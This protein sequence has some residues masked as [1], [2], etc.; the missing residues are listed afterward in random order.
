MPGKCGMQRQEIFQLQT[1]LNGICQAPYTN[2][3][4]KVVLCLC[5]VADHSTGK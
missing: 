5:P 3:Q 2:D 4:G 1:I